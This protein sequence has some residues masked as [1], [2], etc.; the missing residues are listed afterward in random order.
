MSAKSV[1][2]AKRLAKTK[3]ISQDMKGLI[4]VKSDVALAMK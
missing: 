4:K 1:K 3:S 2:K